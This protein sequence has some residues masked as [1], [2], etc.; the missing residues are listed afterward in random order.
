MFA[1]G[2]KKDF[3]AHTDSLEKNDRP[4]AA[5]FSFLFK[6]QLK[7]EKSFS[8]LRYGALS[9]PLPAALAPPPTLDVNPTH[10]I[11]PQT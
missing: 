3:S 10:P 6:D 8:Q 9:L 1:A 7:A 5:R 4:S 11:H 2:V